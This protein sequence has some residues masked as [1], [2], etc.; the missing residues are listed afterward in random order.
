MP[1]FLLSKWLWIGLAFA[2][3]A[4]W[5][6]WEHTQVLDLELAI[7]TQ[8]TEAA[9][10]L[11][12]A[13]DAAD[14]VN[15]QNA[16][17]SQQIEEVHNAHVTEIE[18]AHADNQRLADQLDSLRNTPRRGGGGASTVSRAP[19]ASGGAAGTASS[20]DQSGPSEDPVGFLAQALVDVAD[21][22]DR[23]IEYGQAC[24]DWAVKVG[25]AP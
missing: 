25:N 12:K 16:Q 11:A 8:K 13:T 24:H 6:A 20:A 14:Q 19:L 23:A 18:A 1:T 7:Q 5:G 17:L 2:G 3:L 10:M 9:N 15:Q 21:S 22:A 4:A